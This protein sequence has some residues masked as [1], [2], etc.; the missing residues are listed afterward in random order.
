M[1]E[2]TGE[3]HS[4]AKRVVEAVPDDIGGQVGQRHQD[5]APLPQPRVGHDQVVLV[6]LRRRRP[7]DVDVEG[8]GTPPLSA[9]PLRRGLGRLGDVEEL[10]G[11]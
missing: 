6:D 7:S 1:L 11:D 3:T 9:D 4:V 2:R 8:A 5:E 10:A